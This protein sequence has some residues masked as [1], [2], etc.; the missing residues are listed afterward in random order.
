MSKIGIPGQ[1]DLGHR[2]GS[3]GDCAIRLGPWPY[4]WAGRLFVLTFKRFQTPTTFFKHPPTPESGV[5][6]LAVQPLGLVFKRCSNAV[7]TAKKKAAAS[8]LAELQ[9][10]VSGPG[11]ETLSSWR[12]PHTVLLHQDAF[13]VDCQ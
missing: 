7:Q 10:G 12:L 4:G 6:T 11:W 13:S 5:Q 2:R 1:I 8:T 3:G 9:M